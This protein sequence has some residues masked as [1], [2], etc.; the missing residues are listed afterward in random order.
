Q[1]V[2]FLWRANG[3]PVGTGSTF[4]DVKDGEYYT[5]AVKWATGEGITAGDTSATFA[6][7][8]NCTRG[9]IVTFLY[10]DKA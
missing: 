6:P 2:T 9:Q 10:R 7:N 4:G 8:K 5:E 3:E 1:A